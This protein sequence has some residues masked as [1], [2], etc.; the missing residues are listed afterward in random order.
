[1]EATLAH[2]IGDNPLYNAAGRQVNVD[3]H[4][5]RDQLWVRAILAF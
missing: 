1:L 3:N 5:L 4:Y 2:R